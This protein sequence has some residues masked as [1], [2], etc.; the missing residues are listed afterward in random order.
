M[1]MDALKRNATATSF[2]PLTLLAALATV[3][4]HLG[5]FGT[6]SA[7]FEP[8][9]LIGRRFAALNPISD[10]RAGFNLVTTSNPNAALNVGMTDHMAHADAR[11]ARLKRV[12]NWPPRRQS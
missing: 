4:K 1:P 2:D 10:G 9:Y 8:P 5:V 12:G 7:T 6:A 11:P 3:T